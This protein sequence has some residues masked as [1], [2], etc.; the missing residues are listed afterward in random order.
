MTKSILSAFEV[1]AGGDSRQTPFDPKL[2]QGEIAIHIATA[3]KRFVKPVL[4]ATFYDYLVTNK[5]TD[6][7]NYNT[8]KGAIVWKYA[9]LDVIPPTTQTEEHLFQYHLYKLCAMAVYHQAL[10][11][12]SLKTTN[13][14]V[15]MNNTE[16]A[17]NQ[18]TTGVKFLQ[19]Q[20]MEVINQCIEEMKEYLEDYKDDFEA[21]G[22]GATEDE[23]DTKKSSNLGVIFH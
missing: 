10:P 21:S 1:L 15:M 18:G 20:A 2:A 7:C 19:Q 11:F 22:Y 8:D 9:N 4:G 16:F 3:E 13:S 23:C 6:S 14:G 12:I 17:N 5:L